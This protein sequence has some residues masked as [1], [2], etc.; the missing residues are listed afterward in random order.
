MNALYRLF[1]RLRI[2]F[3]FLVLETIAVVLLAN[4]SYFQHAAVVDAVRLSKAQI[5]AVWGNWKYYFSLKETNDRLAAE[6]A[7]LRSRIQY[8][9]EKNHAPVEAIVI[10]STNTPVFSYISARIVTNNANTLHNYMMLNAGLEQGVAPDMGV[11][12]HNGIVGLVVTAYDHYSLVKSLLNVN[13]Q[14]SAKLSKSGFFGPMY[15]NGKNYR[16][17]ILTEIPQHVTVS[18][19]DTIVSSGFSSLFPPDI[20]IGTVKS[21]RVKGGSF[22]EITVS[23]FVDFRK[24]YEVNVVKHLY[25][26]EL[27]TLEAFES[28]E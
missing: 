14:V 6:N 15:W 19:G 21:Y 18:V 11:I 3:V 24:L 22:Y 16:E 8:Y 12:V 25:R 23:L 17:V 7:E 9:Q 2:F 26:N 5:D 4:S 1:L 10:D 13:W 28:Y 20:P 27:K